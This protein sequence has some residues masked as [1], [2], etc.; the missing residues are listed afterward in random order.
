MACLS[1]DCEGAQGFIPERNKHDRT[2]EVK[3]KLDLQLLRFIGDNC[4]CSVKCF[5]V[6]PEKN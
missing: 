2:S 1:T 6:V 4:N 5:N 3:I